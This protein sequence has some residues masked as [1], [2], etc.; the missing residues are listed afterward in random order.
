MGEFVWRSSFSASES[1][2]TSVERRRETWKAT[3]R[4]SPRT[5]KSSVAMKPRPRKSGNAP[6][7]K[8]RSHYRPLGIVEKP[9]LLACGS[10]ATDR[11]SGDFY[12]EFHH[13]ESFSLIGRCSRVKSTYFSCEIEKTMFAR[14]S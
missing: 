14:S 13:L 8:P 6:A 4:R 3:K 7:S 1:S 9:Y 2:S 11:L 12:R 5:P 10:G